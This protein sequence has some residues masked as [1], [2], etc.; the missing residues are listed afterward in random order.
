MA[1]YNQLPVYL[2]TQRLLLEVV[3][4]THGVSREHRYTLCSSLKQ[5]LVS[6]LLQIYHANRT[7]EKLPCI[8]KGRELIVEATIYLHLLS[9]LHEISPKQ[10]AILLDLSDSAS[11]Q[12]QAWEKFILNKQTNDIEN[13]LGKQTR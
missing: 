5:T 12:L 11:K 8:E 9:E 13:P 1:L 2:T 4:Q 6:L 7:R 10:Y 3:R